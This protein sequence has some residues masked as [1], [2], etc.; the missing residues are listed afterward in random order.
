M[1]VSYAKQWPGAELLLYRCTCANLFLNNNLKD[2][3]WDMV[4]NWILAQIAN[5]WEY[6]IA[7]LKPPSED[8]I[9]PGFFQ[10]IEHEDYSSL[11]FHTL[12]LL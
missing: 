11:S 2:I 4:Q 12:S 8:G 6:E 1:S 5:I 3:S 9:G 10:G 7:L